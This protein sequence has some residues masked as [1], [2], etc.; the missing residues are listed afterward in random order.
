MFAYDVF[1]FLESREQET[2]LLASRLKV[3]YPG[4]MC[5]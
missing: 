4:K 5:S 2:E 3:H 1:F